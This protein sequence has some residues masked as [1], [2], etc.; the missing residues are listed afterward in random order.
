M[1]TEGGASGG[2]VL[3]N[4]FTSVGDP[5]LYWVGDH[6]GGGPTVNRARVL[7]AS[8]WGFI[9]YWGSEY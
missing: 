5:T 7:T 4:L 2:G 3:Q 6:Y 9:Q 8:T 1:D